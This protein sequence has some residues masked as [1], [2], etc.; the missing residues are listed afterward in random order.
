MDNVLSLAEV[1]R[2]E[3]YS[4]ET[5]Q[6]LTQARDALLRRMPD[7]TM[8]AERIGEEGTLDLIADLDLSR[9]MEIYLMS[10]E[11]SLAIATR[12][13]E[14]GVTGYF[15]K[16]VDAETLTARLRE[17]NGDLAAENTGL[18]DTGKSARGLLV[19]ESV[20]MQRLY[21]LIRKSAPSEA[22]VLVVGESGS[23][24][25]LVARA[26]HELSKRAS[27]PFVALNCSA[28]AS[29]LL[30]SELFGHVKGSFTGASKDHSG[31][32]ERAQG[33][34]LFLDEITEMDVGLQAKLLRV[35]EERQI[36]PVGGES[37]IPVDTR[38]LAATNQDPQK[39]VDD[40]ILRLD[41]YYR[42]AQLPVRVPPLR[43]RGD[44]ILLLAEHFLAIENERN[45]IDKKLSD[46]A[47][48]ALR[49]HDWPGN[50]REL[51]NAIIHGHLLAGNEVTVDDLPNGI[52]SSIPWQGSNVRLGVGMPLAEVER[53][54]VLSTLAHCE[55]NKKQAAKIL[56]ISL[57]TLYNR[58]KRYRDAK[59]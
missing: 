16:P 53:R 44:D 3:G 38:I 37:A 31:Y 2:A 54:Y 26:I 18:D 15:P 24:K 51:R 27:G 50:V 22:T 49:L 58:L 9:V 43:E 14:L 52:P 33:G 30:E 17:L 11:R 13:M 46:R 12:A 28:I 6:D 21:R 10:G 39:G 48:E 36:R 32:F 4:T 55:G 29:E 40:G 5:A 57:K 7:V 59:S 25:E 34:T 47:I 1:F 35:L 8:L 45:E 42:L 19:G 20:P 23:G 56:G 41:L